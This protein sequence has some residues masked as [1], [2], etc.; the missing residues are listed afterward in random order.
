MLILLIPG[1]MMGQQLSPAG[2]T[3]GEANLQRDVLDVAE[4]LATSREENDGAGGKI[5]NVV[6]YM[7]MVVHGGRT[8]Q[9]V[10]LLSHSMVTNGV[11]G[12]VTRPGRL[13][14]RQDQRMR[15]RQDQRQGLGM[16]GYL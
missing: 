2:G 4:Y 1:W 7:V 11:K 6:F 12:V 10:C 14:T 5:A 15:R 16:S 8:A 9:V 13:E 3:E